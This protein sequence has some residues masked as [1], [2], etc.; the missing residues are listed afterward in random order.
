[1]SS[2]KTLRLIAFN[3]EPIALRS[4]APSFLAGINGED[5]AA[6]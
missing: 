3:S 2:G 1:M 6:A 5:K 4:S